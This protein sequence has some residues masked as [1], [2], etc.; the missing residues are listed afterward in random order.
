M[1][2]FPFTRR[3]DLTDQARRERRHLRFGLVGLGLGM[4]AVVG[5]IAETQIQGV[6]HRTYIQNQIDKLACAA[7]FYLP[8][9]IPLGAQLRTTYDCPPYVT[10]SPAPEGPTPTASATHSVS[11]PNPRPSATP[12]PTTATVTVPGPTS[13]RTKPGPTRTRTRTVTAPAPTPTDPICLVA[14][15]LCG[16]L[17]G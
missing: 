8:D 7:D 15:T 6:E 1:P 13:V 3:S 9:D 16:P 10:P 12:T 14:P 17:G 5:V 11:R 4:L 2:K